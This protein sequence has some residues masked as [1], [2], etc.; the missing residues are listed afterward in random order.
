[1]TQPAQKGK[2]RKPKFRVEPQPV[3]VWAAFN[4]DTGQCML[5]TVR[6]WAGGAI[7]ERNRYYSGCPIFQ[8]WL[9][10]LFRDDVSKQKREPRY[11]PASTE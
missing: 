3:I 5:P 2:R 1:M 6:S 11:D 7:E 8:C 4:P 10:P 9:M